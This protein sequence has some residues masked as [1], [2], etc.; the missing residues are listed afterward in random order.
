MKS[1]EQILESS[2][3]KHPGDLDL[4]L[5]FARHPAALI[6]SERLAALV[7]HEPV[8]VLRSLDRL[9]ARQLLLRLPLPERNAC[10]YRFRAEHGTP[11]AREILEVA[12]TIEGRRH[13]R[14]LLM[15]HHSQPDGPPSPL[16]NEPSSNRSAAQERTYA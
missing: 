12:S 11:W 16:S 4:L 1:P 8:Q 14:R 2:G 7:G 9:I 3:L 15:R 5:F 6:S 10:W 13:L